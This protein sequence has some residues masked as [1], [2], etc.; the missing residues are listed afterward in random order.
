MDTSK[1]M[2]VINRKAVFDLLDDQAKQRKELIARLPDNFLFYF[3]KKKYSNILEEI[4]KILKSR[5]QIIN[6]YKSLFPD[7]GLITEEK[8]KEEILPLTKAGEKEL[9]D[10]FKLLYLEHQGAS[11][12]V[13]TKKGK[14]IL[15]KASKAPNILAQFD[16]EYPDELYK[17]ADAFKEA[18]LSLPYSHWTLNFKSEEFIIDDQLKHQVR[19]YCSIYFTKEDL[20]EYFLAEDVSSVLNE[21]VKRGIGFRTPGDINYDDSSLQGIGSYVEFDS[22]QSVGDLVHNFRP[23]SRKS[24]GAPIRN[25]LKNKFSKL[26]YWIK[27]IINH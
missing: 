12:S 14:D 13:K 22:P 2:M 27:K 7:F 9:L 17:A 20:Q 18:Y 3:D 16:M 19:N 15:L 24:K 1:N 8:F 26:E 23:S 10:S 21:L 6:I 5:N 25:A 11:L 4:S